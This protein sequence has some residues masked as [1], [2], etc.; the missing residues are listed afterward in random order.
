MSYVVPKETCNGKVLSVDFGTGD[1]ALAIGGENTMPF[2]SFEG[3]QPN[4]PVSPE[5]IKEIER[6]LDEAGVLASEQHGW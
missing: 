5:G 6:V 1:K 3:E 2:L 4:R